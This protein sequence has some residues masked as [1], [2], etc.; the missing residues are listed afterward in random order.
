VSGEIP[1]T[2]RTAL[3]VDDD[4]RLRKV[5]NGYLR[6]LGILAIEAHASR[7]AMRQLAELRPDIICL[8]TVLPEISGYALC[9]HIRRVP[10]LRKTPVLL[11][12]ERGLP[13]D[14]A[15]AEEVGATAYI[16]KP[17][18]RADFC[19]EVGLLLNGKLPVQ[20]G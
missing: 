14:R 6:E 3:V 11:M 20:P 5:V 4:T 18:R 10:Q 7:A 8:D 9:E 15:L 19:R 1:R 2:A 17:F 16:R 13:E 12:S